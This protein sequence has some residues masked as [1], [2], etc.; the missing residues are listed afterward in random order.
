MDVHRHVDEVTDSELPGKLVVISYLLENPPSKLEEIIRGLLLPERLT[1]PTTQRDNGFNRFPTEYGKFIRSTAYRMSQLATRALQ[2]ALWRTG[3]CGG[4]LEI[5]ICPSSLFWRNK[6]A[7]G[8][9][10]KD[11]DWRQV[12]SGLITIELPDTSFFDLNLSIAP[13]IS[14][15]LEENVLQPLGHDLL[16]EAWRIHDLNP[17]A[18][19]VV[20]VAAVETG[21][22][23][24]VACQL[25]QTDWLLRNMPSPPLYKLLKE[26]L[27]TVPSKAKGNATVPPLNKSII[28]SITE[29][30]EKRNSLV[31]V[32]TADISEEWLKRVLG[33][34]RR[35]LYELD[36]HNGNEWA[37]KVSE[38]VVYPCDFT[39][40]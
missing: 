36:Y 9:N 25:P 40:A 31:H 16:R 20:A 6:P 38:T 13:Q 34:V 32:G 7:R 37:P 21:I 18:A 33:D 27:P 4:P 28:R 26:L 19:L 12:P 15:L 24:F 39:Q 17:R 8:E 35:L 29:A 3:A 2:V 5:E 22:K 1:L 11:T 23:Q 30:V 14:Q 10:V